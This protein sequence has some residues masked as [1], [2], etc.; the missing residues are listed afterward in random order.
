[1]S[2]WRKDPVL[3]REERL[4]LARSSVHATNQ[5]EDWIDKSAT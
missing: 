1:M 3:G 5:P 4:A 2:R